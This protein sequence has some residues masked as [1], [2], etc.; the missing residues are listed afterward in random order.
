MDSLISMY[1]KVGEHRYRETYG[2][3]YED[4]EVGDV[5]EH[6]PGAYHH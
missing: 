3:Y 1:K 2:L 6:R 4:F 5:F